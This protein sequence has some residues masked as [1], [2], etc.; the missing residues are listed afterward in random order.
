MMDVNSLRI[1]IKEGGLEHEPFKVLAAISKVCSESVELGRDLVIRALDSKE[2]LGWQ[3]RDILEE[4]VMQVG[5]YPY[6]NNL[7]E[8]SLRSAMLHAAHRADGEMEDFV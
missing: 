3:Y 8:L 1:S 7:P 2:R 4:L 5:L 6:V